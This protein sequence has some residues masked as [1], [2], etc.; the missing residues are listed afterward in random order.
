MPHILTD[1]NFDFIGRSRLFVGISAAAVVGTFVLFGINYFTRGEILNYGTD[2]RGGSE[3]QIEFSKLV[4]PAQVR[5]ILDTGGFKGAEAVS[6][7]DAKRPHYYLMRLSEVSPYTPAQLGNA[8]NE[9][10]KVATVIKFDHP[11]QGDKVFIKFDKAVEP[12][13]LKEAL[14]RAGV[15]ARDIQ[16]FGRSEDHTYQVTLGGLDEELRKLFDGKLGAGTVKEIPSVESV[17]AKVGAQLRNDGIKSIIYSL[18]LILVYVWFRFDFQFAPGGVL[19]LLHDVIVTAGLFALFWKDFTLQTV[20]ALLTI[21][22]Y[23]INDTIVV[24]DRIR[25]NLSRMRDRKLP[26]LVNTSINETLS[27]TVLTNLTVLMTTGCIWYFTRGPIRDFGMAM[28]FGV[29]I[30]T[31]STIFVASPIYLWLDER[32]GRRARRV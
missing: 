6:L 18:L 3:V 25:E 22:G 26:V 4:S 20:A 19:A 8:K 28:T 13:R 16:I 21:A 9:A 30:G 2:F 12:E 10:A 14:A 1:T 32:M 15:A 17:G 23:S 7:K 27:R 31:Y 5:E 11:E 29:F 24:F